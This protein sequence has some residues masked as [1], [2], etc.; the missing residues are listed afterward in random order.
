MI[1]FSMSL[2][3]V[4]TFY[5]WGLFLGGVSA[6]AFEDDL[7]EFD[8]F[9][10]ASCRL[11]EI[12]NRLVSFCGSADAKTIFYRFG[13]EARIELIKGFSSGDPVFRRIDAATYT[14]YFGFRVSKYAYVF[15]VPQET[16]GAKA[17]LEVTGLN[18]DVMNRTCTGNSYGRK[19]V[20]SEAI[21]EVGD[22]VVRGFG[23]LFPPSD[24]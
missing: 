23:Y 20:V 4:I 14:T 5:F 18:G 21:E 2:T 7:C 12:R 3:H 22:A 17:F 16:L 19:T 10:V 8:E 1:L 9:V 15:G 6:N 11:G 24:R 13:T